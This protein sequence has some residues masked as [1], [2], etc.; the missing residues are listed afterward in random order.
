MT[1]KNPFPPPPNWDAEFIEKVDAMSDELKH[2]TDDERL[3]LGAA[4]SGRF[5]PNDQVVVRLLASINAERA[6]LRALLA[7]ILGREPG[8]DVAASREAAGVVAR[9][10]ERH[11]ANIKAR[12]EARAAEAKA[13]ERAEAAELRLD[14]LTYHLRV[15]SNAKRLDA[16]EC[17]GNLI[18]CGSPPDED[19]AW[20]ED[21][22]RRHDCDYMGCSSVGHVIIREKIAPL[23]NGGARAALAGAGE[24]GGTEGGKP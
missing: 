14:E 12:D 5:R 19:D 2:L 23:L 18:V 24:A 4:D 7:T 8:D 10:Q 9:L 11:L 16:W 17:D 22:P 13:D 20:P 3:L 21:D 6:T 15:P 1:L